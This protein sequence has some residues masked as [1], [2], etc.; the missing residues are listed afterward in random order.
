[1]RGGDGVKALYRF[2]KA[3]F[4][5]LALIAGVYVLSGLDKKEPEGSLSS[6]VYNS[7]SQGQTNAIDSVVGGIGDILQTVA[8]GYSQDKSSGTQKL[9]EN[10]KS[11][12]KPD[13]ANGNLVEGSASTAVSAGASQ[14]YDFSEQMYPYR[15]MLTDVQRKVYD[16][17]YE[18]INELQADISLCSY[19]D[20]TG[21]KNVMTAIFNDH[22]ELFWIDT[23]YS[24][25][26]TNKGSVI[27]VRL[28]YNETANNI[29]SS[30]EKFH[31]AANPI[32]NAASTLGTD[33]EKE[34]FVYKA[35]QNICVY[36]ENSELNQSAYSALVLGSS[37]CAG[38]S[39][40]FQYIMMQLNIPCYFCSGYA[41]GGYHAW[42]I[43]CVE[44]KYYN[45]D[46][47]WD[48]SLGDISN[49]LSYSY[50]NKSDIVMSADHARRE[51]ST[52]LPACS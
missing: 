32:I 44:G 17:V 5:M 39:R 46:I 49:T 11:D 38:Y 1:M 52:R 27:S 50:F 9:N 28:D 21:I 20:V 14:N 48:D 30:R 29:E 3:S 37:V 43:V 41:N 26:Y 24:Y 6:K 31:S 36:D 19:L 7:A 4:V 47:S 33:I 25:G 35:V 34:K 12:Y 15:A 13:T 18:G 8:N 2:L 40:A 45:V 22:P 51:M 10:V 42:N 23:G 16:Q